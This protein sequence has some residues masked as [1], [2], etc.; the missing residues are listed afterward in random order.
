MPT[1]W[2]GIGRIRNRIKIRDTLGVQERSVCERDRKDGI[3][4]YSVGY[5]RSWNDR[6]N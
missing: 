6:K 2:L 4:M 3:F 5:L 1:V